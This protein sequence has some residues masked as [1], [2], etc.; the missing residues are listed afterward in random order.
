MRAAAVGNVGRSLIGATALVAAV[1]GC[2]D[3]HP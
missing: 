1:A 2:Q 3:P